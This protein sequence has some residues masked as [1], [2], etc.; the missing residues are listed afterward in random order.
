L[1]CNCTQASPAA[2]VNGE[3]TLFSCSVGKK[4]LAVCASHG[5]S[6]DSGS[7]QYRFGRKAA[8]ELVL[9][10]K[11]NSHPA[12]SASSGLLVFTGGGGAYLRFSQ[13]DTDYVVYSAVSA[14]WGE[15]SG[16]SV[17]KAGKLVA[18]LKCRDKAHSE[19]GPEL[20]QRG[21]FVADRRGFVLPD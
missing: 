5:W 16:V 6:A 21:G 9:P 7:L 19:L 15:K 8:A 2:C 4:Q 12:E 14:N 18:D 17:L 13:G 10:N 3:D 20:F 11:L 1:A